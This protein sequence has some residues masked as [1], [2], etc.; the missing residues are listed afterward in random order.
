MAV[1]SQF[2]AIGLMSGT[3]M[4][5]IDAAIL[6]TDGNTHLTVGPHAST[7]YPPEL[8]GYIPTN[9]RPHAWPANGWLD[10]PQALATLLGSIGVRSQYL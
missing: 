10:T 8:F 2:R 1:A 7:R 3:S 4:D 5:G 6:E 9:E